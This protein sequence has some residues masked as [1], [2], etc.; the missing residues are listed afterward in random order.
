MKKFL[1]KSE[2]LQVYDVVVGSYPEY[3]KM[4]QEIS[5]LPRGRVLEIGVG[6]GLL[7]E[8]LFKNKEIDELTLIEPNPSFIEKFRTKFPK[9]ELLREDGLTF[10]NNT[11]FNFIV[12]SQVYHHIRD[13]NK[14]AFLKN[15]YRNLLT[16]GVLVIGDV[17]IPPYTDE[18]SRN[19]SL[20]VFHEP[21]IQGAR[22]EVNKMVEEKALNDGLARNGE[23]KTSY[24]VLLNQL[25]QVGFNHQRT[26]NIG[27]QE[28]GGYK[29]VI[30]KK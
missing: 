16:N 18:M 21:R 25:L 4:I 6:T 11:K 5:R 22:N 13:G 14:V 12:I 7:T 17:F 26:I 23:Y 29:I 15:M 30:A 2:V 19:E 8:L 24:E 9:Q 27:K 1:T 28:T 20:R 10:W 3:S